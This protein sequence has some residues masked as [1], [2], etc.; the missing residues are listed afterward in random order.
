[1]KR[2]LFNATHSEELRVATV[3]GQKL[4]DFDI[5][6]AGKQQRKGNIYK[7][8]ITRIEPSLEAC[9]VNYGEDR[10]GFLP[11]KEISRPHSDHGD[12][13]AEQKTRQLPKEGAEILVQVD[14]EERGNKGAALTTYLSLAGRY[15]VLMPNNPKGG[16]ISRRIE[17]E[18][19]TEIKI[20]LEKLD[21]P[22]GMSLI[23][24]TAGI[25]RT[26]EELT[27]D[28]NYL[29]QL[30]DAIS[31]AK[32]MQPGA[33]LIYQESS[34]VIR[35]IRDYFNPNIGEILVDTDEIFDQA[36]QFMQHVMPD[37]EERVKKYKD[38]VPL[39]SRY[40]IEHQ[41]ETAYS[42]I[43]QLPLGGSIVIDHSEAL[44][45]VDVNSAKATKGSDIE[46]TAVKTNLEAAEEIGRQLRLRDIGGLIVIDFIDMELQKNQRDV[47]AKLRNALSIDRARVQMGKI[48][49]FGLME[50]SR[51]RLR[52]ALNEG[53]HIT[54]KRCNGIG[55]IRDINSSG[56]H[57]LRILQDEA[58]KDGTSSLHAQVPIDVATFLLN[59]KRADIN[60]LE[61]S[62]KVSIVLIPNKFLE[63][64]N[65]KIQR[66]KYDD[67][68]QE[69]NNL[70]Y[71]LSESFIDENKEKQLSESMQTTQKKAV[72]DTFIPATPAPSNSK[73]GKDKGIGF[74]GS[75]LKSLLSVFTPSKK[76]TKKRRYK[77]DKTKYKR[78]DK[79]ETNSKL[80]KEAARYSD[81]AVSKDNTR[82]PEKGDQISSKE[83]HKKRE[84]SSKARQ[85]S[86]RTNK[87]QKTAGDIEQKKMRK[88]ENS[89]KE[90]NN[91]LKAERTKERQKN[92]DNKGSMSKSIKSRSPKREPDNRATIP[93][94][95]I[96]KSELS[97]EPNFNEKYFSEELTSNNGAK[98][99]SHV[100]EASFSKEKNL[101]KTL[102]TVGLH[103][104]ETRIDGNGDTEEKEQKKLGRKIKRNE[105]DK[106]RD[107]A[108]PLTMVETKK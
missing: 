64:P 20:I 6:V 60:T 86:L 98:N 106:L 51:Q 30:W 101:R 57:I 15:L 78:N 89:L 9:F 81:K 91:S 4:L 102:E 108:E 48:S 104:V 49:K 58:M 94:P 68:R 25:G 41:I 1:M 87:G 31:N 55:V 47:E 97:D 99:D 35:A 40:Q 38:E 23:V 21:I 103:L 53:S 42:R 85:A 22:I 54:C 107:D 92:S 56:L 75:V 52:P 11:F 45:A 61:A 39:F 105:S 24:R 67:I 27:W 76:N 80:R 34:L 14:K 44:V 29:L 70:S 17:G 33:Y 5:E 12:N 65:Y 50:L 62:L 10:H 84:T 8:I 18:E 88:R 77:K 79:K 43:V 19:R 95:T 71:Q 36:H 74:I 7:G 13:V 28:M 100:A 72:I 96:T 16:G 59:E 93:E 63:T 83:K 69:E 3:D 66:I 82:L 26:I 37:M 32:Q 46:E 2:M 73:K 90:E